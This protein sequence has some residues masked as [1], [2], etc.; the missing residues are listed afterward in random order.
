MWLWSIADGRLL[1]GPFADVP[2]ELVVASR[3]VK[4]ARPPHV[5]ALA[6]RGDVVATACGAQVQLW[7]VRTGEPRPA[8]DV[9]D[10][11]VV[12]LALGTLDEREVIV[13]GSRGGVVRVWDAGDGAHIAG[14]TL[15]AG[16]DGVWVVQGADSVAALTDGILHVLDIRQGAHARNA[17]MPGRR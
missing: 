3:R 12:S 5:T 8:P 15:D 4:A 1:A 9:G 10:E 17:V 14:I 16:V 2:A 13:T 6:V 7:D 11:V